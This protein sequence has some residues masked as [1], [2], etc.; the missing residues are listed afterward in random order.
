MAVASNRLAANMLTKQ[1]EATVL[2][3]EVGWPHEG[4]ADAILFHD[5]DMTLFVLY[6]TESFE[7]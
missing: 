4:F 2:S 3:T 1:S 6:P 5:R 7:F